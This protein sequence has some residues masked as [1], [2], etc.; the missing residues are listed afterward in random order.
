MQRTQQSWLAT[1]RK[2]L[3]RNET[4]VLYAKC[5]ITYSGRAESHLPSGDRLIIIK[6]DK[7]ILI[8]QPEGSTPVNYMKAGTQHILEEVEGTDALLL[9]SRNEKEYLDIFLERIY[10]V[11]SRKLD[12]GKKLALVGSERDMSDM[13]YHNPELI[14]AG[15]TPLSRE[16]HTKYGFIDVFGYDK[17]GVLVVVECKRY[18]GDLSAV[19]QLRR[20]VEKIKASKGLDTVR[21]V[22]ACPAITPNAK[23][24]LEDW[25]FSY[26]HVHP[27]KYLE[28][29]KKGQKNLVEY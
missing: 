22:L 15:F 2:A 8:H 19:T 4:L 20:Y 13:L 5:E 16:E 26:V 7:T 23:K 24:M 12:D 25:H 21:G 17:R 9:K 1:I 11:E 3:E 14:E 29:H 6:S 28:K 27:P 18:V 10:C